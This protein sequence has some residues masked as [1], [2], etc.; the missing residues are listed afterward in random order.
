MHSIGFLRLCHVTLTFRAAA[1]AFFFQAEDGIRDGH[2][3]GVQTCA[4]PICCWLK[5][6][7]PAAFACALINSWPMGF[8][9]PDQIL[10]DARRHGIEVRPVDV[11]YSGWESSLEAMSRAGGDADQPA[12][13]LGL[14]FI[15]GLH[16]SAARRIESARN[17]R[18]FV[19]VEDLS[20]R[21]QL[22]GRAREQLA[23]A[24]A[25]RGLAGHRH[26]ARW[27]VAGVEP[28]LPL[29]ADQ[30][31]VSE[32]AVTLPL[33]SVGEELLTDYATL[34]TTLGSHPLKLLRGRL[35]ALRCRSSREAATVESGRPVRV[36]GLA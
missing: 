21:A 33:P 5:C 8:Y 4:L 12:I 28:Q 19:D 7:E 18:A 22:D 34:G 17:D 13:R 30:L 9:S 27:A 35:K 20:R 31:A 11:R 26:R 2:V 15:R 29:F 6:H 23:D 10:Q 3:T 36:A 1:S 25:L 16:E 14:R 24:G 32:P